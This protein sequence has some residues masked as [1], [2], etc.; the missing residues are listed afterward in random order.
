M[1]ITWPIAAEVLKLAL[2]KLRDEGR[3][4]IGSDLIG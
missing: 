2:K 1:Y 4:R 3:R